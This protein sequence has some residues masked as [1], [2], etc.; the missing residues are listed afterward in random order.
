VAVLLAV[1]VAAG[2]VVA[3]VLYRGSTGGQVQAQ[4]TRL[5][6]ADGRLTVR[7]VVVKPAADRAVCVLR[8]Y[9]ARGAQIGQSDAV[10]PAGR[11]SVQITRTLRTTGR[12]VGARIVGCRLS[13]SG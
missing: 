9:D 11:R 3:L 13:A 5:D 4:V 10:A 6:A 8:A 1:V 12:P 7:L 2:V